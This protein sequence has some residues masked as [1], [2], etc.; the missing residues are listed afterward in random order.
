MSD[1]LTPIVAAKREYVAQQKKIHP[2]S[3][4]EQRA[5][6]ASPPRGFVSALLQTAAQGHFSLI[7][8]MKR[9]SPSGGPI[10][11]LFDPGEIAQNY[12]AG[13][14]ACL[15][16]LTD[17]PFFGGHDRDLIDARDAVSLPALRKDFMIDPYQIVESRALGADCILLI[18]AALEDAELRDL[19]SETVRLGM[20]VLIEVHN[21]EELE[22]ALALNAGMIG[23]NNRDLKRLKTDLA[24][25]ERLAPLI[26]DRLIIAESGLRDTSDL[27]RMADAGAKAFLVGESLLRQPDITAATRQLLGQNKNT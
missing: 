1:A 5:A 9:Q 13:G 18:V 22:R 25:F 23:I 7:A 21:E 4:V 17:T 16:I 14:A 12:A 24:T 20:D 27:R 15:S 11:P 26:P 8:E 6:K 19:A 2:L 10:R 3:E